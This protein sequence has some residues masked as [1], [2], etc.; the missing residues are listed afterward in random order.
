[1]TVAD[2]A[3]EKI[4]PLDFGFFSGSAGLGYAYP[5]VGNMSSESV[6]SF[7]VLVILYFCFLLLSYLFYKE[8][9]RLKILSKK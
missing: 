9:N 4:P 2:P 5:P 3:D 6:N 1:M 7:F 8:I